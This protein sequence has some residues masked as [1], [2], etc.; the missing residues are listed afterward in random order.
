M[1][2]APEG[3]AACVVNVQVASAASGLPAT[4]V[5]PLAPPLIVAV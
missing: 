1:L 4:S 5:T 3:G 2:I